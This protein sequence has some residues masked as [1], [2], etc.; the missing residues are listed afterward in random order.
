MSR[1]SRTWDGFHRSQYAPRPHTRSATGRASHSRDKARLELDVNREVVTGPPHRPRRETLLAERTTTGVSP[2]PTRT[3]E[4]RQE[5]ECSPAGNAA[6]FAATHGRVFR[7]VRIL[8]AWIRWHGLSWELVD[9][10]TARR[11]MRETALSVH[12]EASNIED[13]D[14]SARV[15]AWARQGQERENILAALEIAKRLP[16]VACE[17]EEIEIPWDLV[18]IELRM[19]AAALP[20]VGVPDHGAI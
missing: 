2:A 3:L 17:L 13:A 19:L 5:L 11:R 15:R 12:L 16:G 9:E 1:L 4:G 18:E 8:E 14:S 10:A 7:F 6:R 20:E